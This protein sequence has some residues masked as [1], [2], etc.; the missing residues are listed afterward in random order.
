MTATAIALR[1]FMEADAPALLA[2]Y[3]G[4]SPASIRTFRPLGRST[5][6][7]ACK[8]IVLDTTAPAAARYDLGAWRGDALIGWGFVTGLDAGRPDLGLAVADA[9]QGQGIGKALIDGVL[10]HVRARGLPRAYLIAVKDNARAIG[11][12]S[13]RGFVQYGEMIGDWDGL[14]YVQM[15]VEF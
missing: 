11:L 15:V 8:K 14:P 5:T 6:L 2:F 12:Y 7:D 9:W 1:P 13:S 10:A 3:N 4:L